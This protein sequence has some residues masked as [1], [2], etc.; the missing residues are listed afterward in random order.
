MIIES[1]SHE[2]TR[3][4]ELNK[5]LKDYFANVIADAEHSEALDVENITEE[6]CKAIFNYLIENYQLIWKDE[7]FL[8]GVALF[9][10]TEREGN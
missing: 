10:K 3:T 5:F 2:G 1:A 7:T 9:A 8:R 6:K 4:I